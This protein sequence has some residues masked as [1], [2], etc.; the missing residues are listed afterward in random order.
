MKYM[1]PSLLARWLGIEQ[2]LLRCCVMKRQCSILHLRLRYE[3]IV[4]KSLTRATCCWSICPAILC[5]GL[6]RRAAAN[7][8][9]QLQGIEARCRLLGKLCCVFVPIL[10]EPVAQP[11]DS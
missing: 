10:L 6:P 1:S 7:H 8:S 3:R 2:Q 5:I 11:H 4:R 9:G